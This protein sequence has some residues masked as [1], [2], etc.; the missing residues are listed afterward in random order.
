ME[1][2]DRTELGEGRYANY[3][4]IGH[5]A[6]EFLLDLGQ[7]GLATEPARIYVRVITSPSG[8][9]RLCQLLNEALS[10]YHESFGPILY[11]DN[12]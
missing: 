12:A 5:N 9:K 10:Q 8:A 4:E 6:F 11:E 7:L 2:A 3:F 1:E